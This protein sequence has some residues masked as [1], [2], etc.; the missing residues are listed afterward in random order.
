MDNVFDDVK[1]STDDRGL[2]VRGDNRQSLVI[3]IYQG[4]MDFVNR[5][6]MEEFQKLFRVKK[7]KATA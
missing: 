5:P 2:D 6:G 3:K 1:Y 7:R 4:D